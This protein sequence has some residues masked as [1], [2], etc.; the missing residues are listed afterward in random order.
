MSETERFR[1]ITSMM[2]IASLAVRRSAVRPASILC[3]IACFG[4]VASAQE[5]VNSGHALDENLQVGS[6]GYNGRAA[7][8][9]LAAR[10]YAPY[11]NSPNAAF[12]AQNAA[13]NYR[14][15]L[16][17]N[18]YTTFLND[19]TYSPVRPPAAPPP[20]QAAPPSPAGGASA[21]PAATT[22]DGWTLVPG[23]PLPPP[24][25]CVPSS[26]SNN[27]TY[28]PVAPGAYKVDYR[29]NGG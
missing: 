19:R 22:S 12:V 11:M 1:S 17:T 29:I 3:C 28:T 10:N 15:G 6:Y 5:Q 14:Y 4:S 9:P 16:P 7:D 27:A 21:P 25:S 26:W 18:N 23:P 24:S 8:V 13:T 2:S 20:V